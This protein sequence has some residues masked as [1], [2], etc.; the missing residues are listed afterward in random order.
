MFNHSKENYEVAVGDRIVQI[1][2]EKKGGKILE[3]VMDY[4]KLKEI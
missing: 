2:F 3:S 4:Q 1:V